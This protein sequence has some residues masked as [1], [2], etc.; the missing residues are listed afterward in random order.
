MLSYR[1]DLG[2]GVQYRLNLIYADFRGGAVG[3]SDDN[4]GVALTT[5]VFLSF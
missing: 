2:P 4:Q 3:S 5:A 1:R